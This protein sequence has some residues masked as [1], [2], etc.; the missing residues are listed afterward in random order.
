MA[1]L[2]YSSR[3]GALINIL[4]IFPA[5]IALKGIKKNDAIQLSYYYTWCLVRFFV[6]RVIMA[7]ARIEE[8]IPESLFQHQCIDWRF[9]LLGNTVSILIEIYIL[10]IIFSVANLLL[11]GEIILVNNGQEVVDLVNNAGTNAQSLGLEVVKGIPVETL[12]QP[13]K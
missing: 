10:F 1:Y 13:N 6:A 3:V 11:K 8:C 5:F 9:W 7:V 2:S 12:S 4:G